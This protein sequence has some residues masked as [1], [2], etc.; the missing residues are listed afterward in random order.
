LSHEF[1]KGLE[2]QTR[3]VLWESSTG[4]DQNGLLWA[5][6]TDNYIRVQSNGPLNLF[7]KVVPA[8]LLEAQ[9]DKTIAALPNSYGE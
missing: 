6:Y 1:H 8:R 2:G 3:A 4:A 7:N 5:G 9:P